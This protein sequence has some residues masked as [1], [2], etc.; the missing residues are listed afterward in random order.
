MKFPFDTLILA[1]Q[2]IARKAL[3]ESL[4]LNVI[5]SPTFCDETH[6]IVDYR[7]ATKEIALRK[8][9]SY[10]DHHSPSIYPIIAADTMVRIDSTILG[11]PTDRDDAASQL[12][13]LSGRVHSVCSGYAL[14][15]PH[16]NKVYSGYS[17]TFVTFRPLTQS[18]IE[19]YLNT[20]EYIGA[21]ASYRIQGEGDALIS[22]IDGDITTVVGLP[23]MVISA[24]LGEPE[25][26]NYQEYPP[27]G[28]K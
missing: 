7:E 2:S 27:H 20:D 6:N 18:D 21:A 23:M 4:G 1:S 15:L 3:L 16:M 8:L 12:V 10:I 5:T 17:E 19:K 26:F 28:E 11:K 24:I 14:F 9:H 25:N 13:L 22:S